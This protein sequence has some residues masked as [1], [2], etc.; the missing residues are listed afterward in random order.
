[1]RRSVRGTRG[2]I[3][4]I[5]P[6]TTSALPRRKESPPGR[7]RGRCAEGASPAVLEPEGLG[8]DRRAGLRRSAP[9]T[10]RTSHPPPQSRSRRIAGVERILRGGD[11]H[12]LTPDLPRPPSREKNAPR[13]RR[14][15]PGSERP[16]PAP[17]GAGGGSA[18]IGGSEPV[19]GTL[20]RGPPPPPPRPPPGG[21]PRASALGGVAVVIATPT[22]RST[23]RAAS[24]P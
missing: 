20:T 5:S 24:W 6:R 13:D 19:A 18:M 22:A 7:R 10:A 15:R 14:R 21:G 11:H 12:N 4:T 2:P 16:A 8:D 9:A 17:P 23:R 1:M 3:I